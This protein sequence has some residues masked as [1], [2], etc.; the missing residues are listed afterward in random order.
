MLAIARGMVVWLVVAASV[1]C[2]HSSDEPAD[3]TGVIAD[4]R[5]PDPAFQE[6]AVLH[7]RAAGDAT[8]STA[9]ET[10]V[11][12]TGNSEFYVTENGV[13]RRTD[14]RVLKSGQTIDVWFAERTGETNPAAHQARKIV[15]TD[16][17]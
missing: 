1:A 11:T 8:S 17:R 10:V 12:L 14:Y 5:V 15:V 4:V 16:R 13:Q 3:V 7:V 6:L 9:S 2:A